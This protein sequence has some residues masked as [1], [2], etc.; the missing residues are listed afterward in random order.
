MLPTKGQS[1][2]DLF[3]TLESYREGDIAWRSGRSFGFVY[4]AGPEVEAVAKQAFTMY[5]SEN[6]LDPTS[7]PSL[8]RIENELMAM[9]REHLHGGP[10]AAGAFTSG[11]TESILCAVKA[12]RDLARV[13]RPDVR[14][15]E[16]V[17][18]ETAHAAFHKAGHY[19]GVKPVM[20]GV[21]PVTMAADPEA[22]RAA[23]TPRTILVV[24]SAPSYAHG[25]VDPVR[26]IAAM[27]AERDLPC[28][29]DAC[30]GGWLLPFF[31]R[32]GT[33]VPEYDFRV[34][35]VTSISMDLHK[36]AFAPKGASV[37]MYR[38]AALRRHQIFACAG[39]S[40]YSVVNMTV[41]S[42]KSGGPV[43]AAWA[44]LRF[45]GDEGYLDLARRMRATTQAVIE[46][47]P[48]A[49]MRVVGRP[50]MC[51]LSFTT[52][53]ASVFHVADEMRE[54]GWYV[55]PQLRRGDVRENL[56]LTIGP[57]NERWIPRFLDDLAAS[58]ETARTLP[59]PSTFA[60][61]PSAGLPRRLAPVHDMLNNL[62]AEAVEK[63]LV[64][65]W[66]QIFR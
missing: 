54:R 50:D 25:V 64:E 32:L 37:I 56:H 21:D 26:E 60:V 53:E 18:P 1:K 49:G 52:E 46:G 6:G 5:L 36:Y 33:E 4:D 11:G 12:A 39:W 31:R 23:I 43:A 38:S 40:G 61:D 62:P 19:F 8:L 28:H 2:E 22:I 63:L 35:G 24:A 48:R 55:Q 17:L 9:A 7:F 58:V 65:Y 47:L 29:V 27:A 15:P 14:E 30:V 44:V 16:M 57:T 41:Q 45:L 20:T 34:P 42:S 59:P 66:T 3:A 51:V 10:E 13:A